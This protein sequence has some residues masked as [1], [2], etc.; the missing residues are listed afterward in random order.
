MSRWEHILALEAATNR[1]LSRWQ[2]ASLTAF[3]CSGQSSSGNNSPDLPGSLK[4]LGIGGLD[5]LEW[6]SWLLAMNWTTLRRLQ[7]GCAFS[8]AMAYARG[9]RQV[10]W[11]HAEATDQFYKAVGQRLVIVGAHLIPTL[12]IEEVCL[13][14]STSIALQGIL[15]RSVSIY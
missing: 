4:D 8:I 14:G 3:R 12:A 15:S 6:S 13:R 5:E 1:C 9:G 2:N 11:D 7:V 10:T